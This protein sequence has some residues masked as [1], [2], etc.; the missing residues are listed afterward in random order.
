VSTGMK[1]LSVFVLTLL[2]LYVAHDQLFYSFAVDVVRYFGID[3]QDAVLHFW[4]LDVR[5]L[6]QDMWLPVG[7]PLLIVWAIYW[8]VRGFTADAQAR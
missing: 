7:L 4:F 3:P 2:L 5:P 8:V 6:V 1:R